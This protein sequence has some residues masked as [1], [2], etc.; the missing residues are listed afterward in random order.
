[1]V[2]E[3]GSGGCSDLSAVG[4]AH[5]SGNSW[6]GW[7]RYTQEIFLGSLHTTGTAW[8][9]AVLL[10]SYSCLLKSTVKSN[11][12]QL[13]HTEY[14]NTCILASCNNPISMNPWWTNRI[15]QA[16]FIFQ[17]KQSRL[18]LW[19][20]MFIFSQWVRFLLGEGTIIVLRLR[21]AMETPPDLLQIFKINLLQPAILFHF[22]RSAWF[23]YGGTVYAHVSSL[24][25]T[26]V[27]PQTL[28]QHVSLHDYVMRN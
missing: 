9:A 22:L 27:D 24:Y 6:N 13:D 19:I 12:K 25:S 28:N 4:F 5:C 26:R 15:S 3:L 11:F 23:L 2:G 18:F 1:M 7:E 21:I 8:M 14:I 10:F 17:M 16:Y 20:S